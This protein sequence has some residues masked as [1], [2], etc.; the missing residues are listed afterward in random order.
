MNKEEDYRKAEADKEN[1]AFFKLN[2][3]P[4]ITRI[5]KFIR[6][7][8]IDELPQLINVFKGDMSL[9]GNRP[10]PIYE[11][12]KLTSDEI[13][14]RFS[15]PAGITG[16]WQVYGKGT[17]LDTPEGR[18]EFDLQYAKQYDFLLD[19]KILWKTLPAAMQEAN[20]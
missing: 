3:D 19:I 1:K 7:T 18:K 10:L 5:G 12:E 14:D 16:L 13:I 2:N 9:V 4:R 17:S 20:T 15:A 6:R 8:S 11:A